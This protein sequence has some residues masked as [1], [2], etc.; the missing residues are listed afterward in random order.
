MLSPGQPASQRYPL[1]HVPSRYERVVIK[2]R[3]TV[4]LRVATVIAV[5]ALE[6]FGKMNFGL[7]RAGQEYNKQHP[8]FQ[9]RA[10]IR[11]VVST[12]TM[13]YLLLLISY[14]VVS[15]VTMRERMFCHLP[16]LVC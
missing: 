3:A 2:T 5:S 1:Y 11:V 10:R 15:T 12:V 6:S 16:I 4:I 7:V 13:L 9:A 8:L 14:N